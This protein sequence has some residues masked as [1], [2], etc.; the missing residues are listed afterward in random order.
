[1]FIGKFVEGFC[2]MKNV[3]TKYCKQC[4]LK[5]PTLNFHLFYSWLTSLSIFCHEVSFN[6]ST[7]FYF[8]TLGSFVFIF[9]SLVSKFPFRVMSNITFQT[10]NR[11]RVS[12]YLV[13]EIVEGFQMR[14]N[15]V[16][17]MGL[18]LWCLTLLSTIFQL[19]CL[20][21]FYS[22]FNNISAIS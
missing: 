15:P 20:M 2:P 21:V 11:R 14:M 19:Y 12:W 5:G 10:T 18:G 1:L 22:T 13:N 8:R 3:F 4:S 6:Y 16:S 7:L 17:L 9:C